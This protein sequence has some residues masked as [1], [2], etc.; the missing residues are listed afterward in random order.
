MDFQLRLYSADAYL[1]DVNFIRNSIKV[2]GNLAK[3]HVIKVLYSDEININLHMN[4]ALEQDSKKPP[5]K[6]SLNLLG[7]NNKREV[8]FQFNIN[9]FPCDDFSEKAIQ[10]NTDGS[11]KN[12]GYLM[13]LP[14]VSLTN[15]IDSITL[16]SNYEKENKENTTFREAIARMS[17]ITSEAIRFSSVA[18][19]IKEILEN[20]LEFTPNSF[21]IIGWGGHSIAS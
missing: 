13:D 5:M 11:Y 15:L 12:L 3:C 14:K 20:N 8:E 10:L 21:Q 17:I 4:F 9:P 18:S 6:A 16:L 7:F 2:N 1:N 19:G